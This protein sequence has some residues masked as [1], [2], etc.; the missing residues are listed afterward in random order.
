MGQPAVDCLRRGFLNLRANWELVPLQLAQTLIVVIVTLAGLLPLVVALGAGDLID[1]EALPQDLEMVLESLIP[2]LGAE[3]VELWAPLSVALLAGMLIWTLAFFA[4]CYFQAGIF[5][6]LMSGDRQAPIARGASG[7]WRLFRTFSLR[8]FRG[9]AG[10][11][12]WSYFWLLSL[13]AGFALFWALLLLVLLLGGLWGGDRW[14]VMAGV[15]I[16]CG[17]ALPLTFLL[18]V[19]AL[20][21]YLAQVE[22][23]R[24]EVGV[25]RALGRSLQILGRRLGAVT[26]IFV[27]MVLAGTVIGAFFLPLSLAVDVSLRESLSGWVT[28]HSLLALLQWMA[29]AWLTV[30]FAASFVAL[31]RG[32]PVGEAA[33]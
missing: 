10:R 27:L 26:L 5:G 30:G 20:W 3:L 12:V 14:G 17:G 29:Q 33:G 1:P 11:F 28:A 31:V 2:A 19:L 18:V 16:G 32:E 9:W 25:W 4:F 7:A 6:I 8:D 22:L 23:A 13:L 24:G 21:T 15:G